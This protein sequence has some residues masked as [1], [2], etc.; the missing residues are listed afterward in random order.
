[1]RSLCNVRRTCPQPPEHAIPVQSTLRVNSSSEFG[2]AAAAL[3]ASGVICV[4]N[5]LN[6]RMKS[7][8]DFVDCVASA[9]VTATRSLAARKY[10]SQRLPCTPKNEFIQPIFEYLPIIC[11]GN[12]ATPSR[13]LEWVGFRAFHSGES[14]SSP[15]HSR[16]TRSSCN[17]NHALP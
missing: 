5:S 3:F 6:I 10:H 11:F 16:K 17:T 4:L 14:D 2:N 13:M 1:M 12:L 7:L 15:S 9:G 8:L